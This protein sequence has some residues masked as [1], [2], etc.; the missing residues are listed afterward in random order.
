MNKHITFHNHKV[1]QRDRNKMNGHKSLVI[2]MSG[3]SG[4]GKSTLAGDVEQALWEKG[5]RTYILDG[6]NIRS[7]L[8][9]D[10]D[11]SDEGRQEN[12][13]RI[14]EVASLM[15]DAGMVVIS[16]FISPFKSDREKAKAIIG[17]DQFIEVFVNTPLEVCEQRDPK[18][19]Y[20]KARAGVIPNFTGI[21]STF[22]APENA[23]IEV[24]NH[25]NSRYSSCQQVVNFI[26]DRIVESKNYIVQHG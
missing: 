22:E 26:E 16:A 4:S 12:I 17:D 23:D 7:G 15:C 20:K 19:L 25:L 14:S 5:I 8:N 6:D 21:S 10:L 2:W 1:N 13:R 9:N 3:L 11:F 18:G 24:R